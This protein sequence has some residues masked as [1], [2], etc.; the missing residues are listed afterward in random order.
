VSELARGGLAMTP[1]AVAP[2]QRIDFTKLVDI[3]DHEE[4]F[5]KDVFI[6]SL[7][8]AQRARVPSGRGMITAQDVRTAMLMLGAAVSE[9]APKKFRDKN[10]S[11]IR[12]ICPYCT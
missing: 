9:A 2:L 4:R 7:K 3:H 1:T 12:D 8:A 5:L 6:S 10:K 11:V